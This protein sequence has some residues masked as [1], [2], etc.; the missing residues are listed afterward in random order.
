MAEKSAATHIN[1]VTGKYMNNVEGD[2]EARANYSEGYDRIFRKPAPVAWTA[3]EVAE[4]CADTSEC[5][6]EPM[7]APC[8][9]YVIDRGE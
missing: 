8:E 6:V 3:D 4:L 1:M 5:S 9:C 7:V 2:P